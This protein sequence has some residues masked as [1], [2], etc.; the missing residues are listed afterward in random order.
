MLQPSSNKIFLA[1]VAMCTV[2][3]HSAGHVPCRHIKIK[4]LQKTLFDEL[5]DSLLQ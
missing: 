1:T 5:E 2:V 4:S 3:E